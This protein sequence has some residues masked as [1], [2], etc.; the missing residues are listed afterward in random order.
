MSLCLAFFEVTDYRFN[1]CQKQHQQVKENL[2]LE[3]MGFFQ[4]AV[5]LLKVKT[6]QGS[7]FL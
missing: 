1:Q 4:D 3:E 6:V 5:L 2:T 7:R